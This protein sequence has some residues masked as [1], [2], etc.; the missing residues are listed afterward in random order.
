MTRLYC[1]LQH[2]YLWTLWAYMPVSDEYLTE[3]NS[4]TSQQRGSFR[5][6]QSIC[7]EFDYVPLSS[8]GTAQ[9]HR[10]FAMFRH[11]VLFLLLLAPL[12]A[13]QFGNIFD[14]MFGGG[15]Q[16]HHQ[17]QQQPQNVPSDSEWYQ[18]TYNGGTGSRS[19]YNSPS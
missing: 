8:T 7:P 6:C 11:L 19:Q 13:A 17:Q 5:A 3:H 18:K 16:Q 9:H 15:G 10:H 12:V 1:A 4:Y 2:G 14:Q